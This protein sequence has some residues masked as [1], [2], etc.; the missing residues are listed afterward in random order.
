MQRTEQDN[1][2]SLQS[3]LRPFLADG[4]YLV[5]LGFFSGPMD[6]LL[7][8]VEQQEVEIEKVDLTTIC[9]QYLRIVQ[10]AVEL[11][12]DRAG[13]YL[14]VA[15]TLVARKS[16]AVL[17]SG[18]PGEITLEEEGYDAR[19]FSE[20]RERLIAYRETKRRAELLL[21]QPQL[22]LQEFVTR[23]IFVDPQVD[24]VEHEEIGG[25]PME[26]GAYFFGLLKRI[27]EAGRLFKVR[28]ESITVVK[29]MVEMMDKL[30]E[31]VSSGDV[32]KQK[33]YTVVS[34]IRD[35]VSAKARLTGTFIATLELVKRGA[36][37]V[38]GENGNFEIELTGGNSDNIAISEFDEEPLGMRANQ[39]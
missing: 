30:S 26:L 22:G 32:G 21:K 29:Y 15:A 5:A 33:F 37:L 11:D 19:F 38:T 17:P 4:E 8:L 12:L 3:E 7:H 25:E 23:R 20:L 13:E 27:G 28:L 35:S 2:E 34:G 9:E 24:L 16:E 1:K 6:L 31:L 36:V 14:V 10:Q 39:Y 18:K